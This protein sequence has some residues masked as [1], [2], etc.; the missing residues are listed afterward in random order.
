M[1]TKKNFRMLTAAD[2]AYSD[3]STD[4]NVSAARKLRRMKRRLLL[5]TQNST[6]NHPTTKSTSTMM[7]ATD[8]SDSDLSTSTQG[9]IDSNVSAFLKLRRMKRK[10]LLDFVASDD[11]NTNDD[12]AS[13]NQPEDLCIVCSATRSIGCHWGGWSWCFSLSFWCTTPLGQKKRSLTT[14]VI[15]RS[16]KIVK[17][18]RAKKVDSESN[19]S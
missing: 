18:S 7:T 14:L 10:L 13:R 3:L 4:S 12:D 1:N 9:S 2:R 15:V 8:R 11:I 19:Q 16:L 6:V 17:K 5:E